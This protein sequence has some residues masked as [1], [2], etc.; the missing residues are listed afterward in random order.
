MPDSCRLVSLS[1]PQS[2]SLVAAHRGVS[3]PNRYQS[4]ASD[5]RLCP[6]RP[7][8]SDRQETDRT[9]LNK[10]LISSYSS[11]EEA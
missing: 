10:Y 3:F 5:C 9:S 8:K 11:S 4:A 1:S 7:D 6:D 2:S